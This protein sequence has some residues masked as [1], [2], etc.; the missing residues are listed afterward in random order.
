MEER[1]S[2][3]GG[4]MFFLIIVIALLTIEGSVEKAFEPY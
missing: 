3:A 1:L 4:D 2:F